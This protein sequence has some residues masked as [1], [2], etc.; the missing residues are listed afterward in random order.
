MRITEVAA[1]ALIAEIHAADHALD[2]ERFLAVLSP[3]V[4]LRLGSQPE[5]HGLESV[6]EAI[7]G[8]FRG[9]S[10]V[11]HRLEQL[12]FGEQSVAFTAVVTYTLK[13]RRTIR[14]PYVDVL[15]FADEQHVDDYRIYI[16]LAPLAAALSALGGTQR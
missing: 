8:L 16:D 3:T 10:G 1:R 11:D 4:R 5:L 7:A 15:R 13:D 14:L 6:R 9:L 2:V 12:W